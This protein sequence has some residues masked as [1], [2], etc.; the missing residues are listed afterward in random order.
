VSTGIPGTGLGFSQ[1]LT[2]VDRTRRANDRIAGRDYT[3][4]RRP[5]YI[6][7]ALVAAIVAVSCVSLWPVVAAAAGLLAVIFLLA[8]AAG[9]NVRTEPAAPALAAQAAVPI[10]VAHPPDEVTGPPPDIQIKVAF[11]QP[12]SE[13]WYAISCLKTELNEAIARAR[14]DGLRAILDRVEV[15]SIR[16]DYLNAV[17]ADHVRTVEA[18]LD[19]DASVAG[20]ATP[21]LSAADADGPAWIVL[22]AEIDRPGDSRD[23]SGTLSLSPRGVLFVGVTRVFIPWA[24]VEHAGW[25]WSVVAISVKGRKTPLRFDGM[26]PSDAARVVRCT[27]WARKAVLE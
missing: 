2:G 23:E 11:A 16:R 5:G 1:S 6:A 7:G 21:P 15:S 20:G 9:T 26:S 24:K 27:M 8:F 18:M 19:F 12:G 17:L 25:D 10:A 3:T 14:P 13:P 4:V 22:S